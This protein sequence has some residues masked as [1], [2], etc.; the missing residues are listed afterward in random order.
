MSKPAKAR[1]PKLVS[2]WRLFR[3]SL[4]QYR[5]GW[6]R[7]VMITGLVAAPVALLS[8]V[9][10]P[11]DAMS[12]AFISMALVVMN[13][14]LVWSIMHHLRHGG[15]PTL[16]SAYYESSSLFLRFVLVSFA[17]V[18]M[19]IPL[20]FGLIL[21]G[22]SL[23][24]TAATPITSGEFGLLTLVTVV[25]GLPSF[26][27]MVKYLLALVAVAVHDLRPIAALRT[28]SRA[29]SGRFWATVG[30]MIALVFFMLVISVPISLITALLAF[31][32]LSALGIM[33]FNLLT[34]IIALPIANLYLF[35]LYQALI[36]DKTGFEPVGP[37]TPGHRP[38]AHH[39]QRHHD[40]AEEPPAAPEASAE[41]TAEATPAQP[42]PT[43]E[44][45][46]PIK[47]INHNGRPRPRLDAMSY[48]P[49]R[50]QAAFGERIPRS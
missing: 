7:Y 27:L 25:I 33:F 50:Y 29:V 13:V 32:K 36:D 2:S 23:M 47:R 14:A 11:D 9:V 46:K 39:N 34:T 28:S 38:D 43:P 21:L 8:M 42:E 18:S 26:Y 12:G 30:R 41:D 20:A 49:A 48:R 17:L 1:R 37:H 22:I 40:R 31:G 16:A 15:L 19:L 35:N 10:R 6:R 24:D 5:A 44:P 3:T 4:G 45:V